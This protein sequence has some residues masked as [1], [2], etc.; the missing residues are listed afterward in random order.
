MYF[1]YN[2]TYHNG[3]IASKDNCTAVCNWIPNLCI[4]I[5]LIKGVTPGKCYIIAVLVP[6]CTSK[7]TIYLETAVFLKDRTREG[8]EKNLGLQLW[9][10]MYKLSE[11]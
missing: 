4:T 7:A 10:G 9:F 11:I 5:T 2:M 3:S 8:G 6:V 1:G